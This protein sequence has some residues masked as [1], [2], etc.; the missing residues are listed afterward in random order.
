MPSKLVAVCE[1]HVSAESKQEKPEKNVWSVATMIV[2]H[3]H[4]T[5]STVTA[6]QPEQRSRW[7]GL[8]RPSLHTR[9]GDTY[10]QSWLRHSRLRRVAA[11]LVQR[12]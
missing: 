8:S 6:A 3:G 5:L 12:L 10:E 4:S 11:A 1:D 9:H 7:E 2:N